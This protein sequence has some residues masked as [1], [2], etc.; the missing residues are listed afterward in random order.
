MRLAVL[1]A[2]RRTQ[3]R[4]RRSSL[5]SSLS[6]ALA[7]RRSGSYAPAAPKEAKETMAAIA[8]EAKAAM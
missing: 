6:K 4:H 2:L 3:R 1:Q 5:M 7:V 8:N